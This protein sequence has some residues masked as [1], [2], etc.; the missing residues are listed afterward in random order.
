MLSA[1]LAMSS[2]ILT[3]A[4]AAHGEERGEHRDRDHGEGPRPQIWYGP[5]ASDF[6]PIFEGTA[7]EGPWDQIAGRVGVLSLNEKTIR[8]MS[9]EALAR[10]VRDLDR[11]HIAF[12]LGILPINWFRETPCGHGIEGYS[13]PNSAK[14]TLAK[15]QTAGAKVRFITMDEP[16]WFGHYY[17]GPQA[18]RSSLDNLAE[19]TSVL[20][21][22]YT[23]SY[24]DAVVGETEPFPALSTQRGW[25]EGYADWQA[26]F[27]KANGTPLVFLDLDFNW[28]DPRL[29]TGGAHDG[30][31]APA[32]A[33]LARQVFS[34]ARRNGLKVGMIYW[35]GGSGRDAQW[36]DNA[37]LH[38]RE[39][40]ASGVHPDHAAFTS[41]NPAPARNFPS[42]DPNALA[43]LIPYYLGN[44]R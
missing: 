11:R 36:M 28:G 2:L 17:S 39:I 14:K 32:V 41:W 19:R 20:V 29:N 21:K 27:Q 25:A 30:S 22:I 23:A 8:G 6:V 33:Q 34:V 15:L 26:A 7:P 9:D 44:R 35:G 24:P 4:A 38:V 37:R 12:G 16:L 5:R 13:D 10:L 3:A 1:V 31:N 42:T 18:C 40:D 43:S